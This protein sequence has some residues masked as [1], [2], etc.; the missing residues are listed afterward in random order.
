MPLPKLSDQQIEQVIQ[1]VAAFIEQQ[2]QT[3]RPPA[4]PLTENQRTAKHL[5]FRRRLWTLRELSS[6]LENALAIRHSTESS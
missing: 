6:L 3:R 4:L 5:F 1:R 2:R